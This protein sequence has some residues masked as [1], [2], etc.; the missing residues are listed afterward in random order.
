[1]RQLPAVQNLMFSRKTIHGY[2]S[3]IIIFFDDTSNKHCKY[4]LS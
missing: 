4:V 1:M 2:E 3:D